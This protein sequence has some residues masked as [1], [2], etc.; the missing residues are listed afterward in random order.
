MARAVVL[1]GGMVGSAMAMD[2]QRAGVAT[3]LVDLRP[4]AAIDTTA[5]GDRI[6]RLLAPIWGSA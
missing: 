1:G 5:A 6:E 3:T 2:M 4:E